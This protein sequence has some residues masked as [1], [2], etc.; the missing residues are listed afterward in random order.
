MSGMARTAALLLLLLAIPVAAQDKPI[1]DN[2]FLLEEAYNQEPG[3][4]QHISFFTRAFDGGWV[5]TFTQE[6]PAPSQKHQLSYTV[7][8]MDPGEGL[9]AGLGDLVLNYRY[10][11]LGSGDTK[12]AF[13][14]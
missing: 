2:S 7:I 9:T 14:P 1:Q 5:Y 11:L 6:W 4:V 10:Q 8:G 13:A 3:V 12:T